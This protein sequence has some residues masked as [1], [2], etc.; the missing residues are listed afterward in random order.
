L[1]DA[2]GEPVVVPS[3][4]GDHYGERSRG[5]SCIREWPDVEWRLVRLDDEPGSARYISAYGCDVDIIESELLYDPTSWHLTVVGGSRRDAAIRAALRD[6]T[7][8]LEDSIEPLNGRDI[9]QVL[10][11]S[12]HMQA[13]IRRAVALGIR[14]EVIHIQPGPTPVNP[15]H[16]GETCRNVR[17]R[18]AG[19]WQAH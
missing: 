13:T 18:C 19:K 15:P 17:F 12:E 14:R 11:G 7:K 2:G 6:V 1:V 4:V 10:A 8:V 5:D 16:R 3:P 9:E